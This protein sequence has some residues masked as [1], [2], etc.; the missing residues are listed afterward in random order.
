MLASM[1]TGPFNAIAITREVAFATVQVPA[2]L[3]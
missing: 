1:V 3:S 2:T